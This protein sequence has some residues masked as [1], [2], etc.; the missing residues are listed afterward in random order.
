[1][2]EHGFTWLRQGDNQWLDG[3][4]WFQDEAVGATLSGVVRDWRRELW[5]AGLRDLLI[6]VLSDELG[7]PVVEVSPLMEDLARRQDRY[8]DV[9]R[10]F[11][12]GPVAAE[13]GLSDPALGLEYLLDRDL[14]LTTSSCDQR[15]G[16]ATAN[17]HIPTLLE[18]GPAPPPLRENIRDFNRRPV[19]D[20]LLASHRAAA[21]PAH[22]DL[23]AEGPTS[24][25]LRAAEVGSVLPCE[26][27]CWMPDGCPVPRGVPLRREMMQCWVLRDPR[28]TCMPLA[29]FHDSRR[30][31]G[32]VA[33][34]PELCARDVILWRSG[35]VL[36]SALAAL[37]HGSKRLHLPLSEPLGAILGDGGALVRVDARGRAAAEG[38]RP[39]DVLASV[40]KRP[41][42]GGRAAAALRIGRDLARSEGLSALELEFQLPRY[43]GRRSIEF[44]FFVY[45]PE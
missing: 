26:G 9:Y 31:E 34:V 39:G 7:A 4:R 32:P 24:H 18:F 17:E 10:E 15:E 19:R 38:L 27:G 11:L 6:A 1:M 29:L 33:V 20:G 13:H 37:A 25:L 44:R 42:R 8:D 23:F 12:L 3:H 16:R 41:V 14:D 5:D 28:V 40:G 21:W 36:H 30:G 2:Q 22:I 43:N 45:W 35:W